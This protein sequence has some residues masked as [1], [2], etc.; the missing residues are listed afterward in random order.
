M[1]VQRISIKRSCTVVGLLFVMIMACLAKGEADIRKVSVVCIPYLHKL[2]EHN[3][4]ICISEHW[5]HENRLNILNSISDDFSVVA[6]SS[7]HSD[8][9]TFGYGRGQG[10][11]ALL[12]RKSIKGVSPINDLVHDRICG[13]RYQTPTGRTLMIYSVY[14]PSPGS[15]DDYNS[16]LDDIAGLLVDNDDGT[17]SIVCSDWNADLGHTG[18]PKSNR[19]PTLLGRTTAKFFREFSLFASNMTRETKGPLNTFR[20]GVGSSTIDYVAL[21]TCI[22][23][24]V[25]ESEVLEDPI[26]NLSDHNAVRVVLE[27]EKHII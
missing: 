4:F 6:R 13:V 25:L 16:V 26:L 10:G 3:D 9:S 15:C 24:L 2:L 22:A 7:K 8:A 17:L 12:W 18:G 21:P 14:L 27:S 23:H 20:G 5:L 11:V 1:P 19:A